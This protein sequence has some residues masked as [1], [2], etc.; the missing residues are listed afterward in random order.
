MKARKYFITSFILAFLLCGACGKRNIAESSSGITERVTDVSESTVTIAP[1]AETTSAPM[2]NQTEISAQLITPTE[3]QKDIS[4]LE[5]LTGLVEY[6][7]KL[8]YF[9]DGIIDKTYTGLLYDSELDNCIVIDGEVRESF[10]KDELIREYYTEREFV[11][12]QMKYLM[13][14]IMGD[15]KYI[16]FDETTENVDIVGVIIDE[17][18]LNSV[19][20]ES[21]KQTIASALVGEPIENIINSAVE[22]AVSGGIS[23]LN[24]TVKENISKYFCGFNVFD[25]IG[26]FEKTE[27]LFNPD[28]TP[29]IMG[30]ALIEDQERDIAELLGMLNEDSVST[31]TVYQTVEL[32]QSILNREEMLADVLGKSLVES[33]EDIDRSMWA[34]ARNYGLWNQRI[35]EISNMEFDKSVSVNLESLN[36]SIGILQEQLEED[37]ALYDF[38]VLP[39]VTEY[40]TK[41]FAYEIT[42]DNSA[43]SLF[44]MLVDGLWGDMVGKSQQDFTIKMQERHKEYF[45]VLTSYQEKS[46]SKLL[47]AKA[48][49]DMVYGHYSS[50]CNAVSED[51]LIIN[52][53]VFEKQEEKIIPWEEERKRLLECLATY[54]FD[55]ACI[56]EYYQCILSDGNQEYLSGLSEYIGGLDGLLAEMTVSVRENDEWEKDIYI[57]RQKEYVAFMLQCIEW[58]SVPMF[59]DIS[60]YTKYGVGY[61]TL[62][63]N[64]NIITV[65]GESETLTNVNQIVRL[66]NREGVPIYIR[67]PQCEIYFKD[68]TPL[69][70]TCNEEYARTLYDIAIEALQESK[71]R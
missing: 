29:V 26:K 59:D 1:K 4:E 55:M 45:R 49:F 18:G 43:S 33:A 25:V 66:Y 39:L 51:M 8:Y 13:L 3:I 69:D 52:Y 54:S 40:D 34:M 22:G 15:M 53:A 14:Q 41:G 64:R 42:V 47:E 27:K 23:Y 56:N 70:Y 36:N 62:Y 6:E 17:S 28:D 60:Q 30:N 12:F 71:L 46:F 50:L 20:A 67:T 10:S 48:E 32:F 16:L 37:K 58:R 61:R 11:W 7:G 44:G 57:E 38:I 2:S 63:K 35:I 65:M 68:G 31:Q 19:A 24:D 9:K 21:L 5:V